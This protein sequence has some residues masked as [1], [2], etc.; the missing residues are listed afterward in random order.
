MKDTDGGMMREG[1]GHLQW[2]VDMMRGGE[3]H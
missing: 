3:G 1:E 2:A